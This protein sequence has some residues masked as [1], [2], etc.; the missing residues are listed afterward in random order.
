LIDSYQIVVRPVVLGGGKKLFDGAG[1]RVTLT[2]KTGSQ[3]LC[4]RTDPA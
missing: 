3:N 1:D 2:L 4:N